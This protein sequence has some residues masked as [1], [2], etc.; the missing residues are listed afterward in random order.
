MHLGVGGDG[1]GDFGGDGDG[2]GMVVY[3][4]RRATLLAYRL[5][6]DEDGK[7]FIAPPVEVERLWPYHEEGYGSVV[8][9]GGRMLCAVWMNMN[10]PFGCAQRH[11]LITTLLVRDRGGQGGDDGHGGV[12]VLHS[13]CRW[14]DMLRSKAVPRYKSYD[15]LCFLQ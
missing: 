13:T 15:V 5:S 12:E 2:D 1:D 3:F 6:E 10:L 11:A 9:L 4:L 7:L 8:H 14:V